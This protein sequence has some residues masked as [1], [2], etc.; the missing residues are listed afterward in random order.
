MRFRRATLF[1]FAAV[2]L[3]FVVRAQSELSMYRLNA[4]LPQANM[5]NP[6]FYPE[7]K[8][9]IGLPVISSFYASVNNDGLA[10]RDIFVKTASDSLTLD[11]WDCPAN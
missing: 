9:V 4:T 1:L 6:A 11:T 10:F 3:P 2:M 7:H 5:L 8:V